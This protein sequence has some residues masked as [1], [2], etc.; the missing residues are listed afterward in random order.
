MVA[1][2]YL[3]ALLL[4]QSCCLPFPIRFATKQAGRLHLPAYQ[5]AGSNG[6]L[7]GITAHKVYPQKLLPA[8]A[9]SSYLTFSPLPRKRGSYFLWHYLFL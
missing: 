1:I 5:K 8:I 6:D 3:A 4:M 2:I 7:R 9:V